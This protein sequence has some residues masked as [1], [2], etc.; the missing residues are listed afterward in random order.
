MAIAATDTATFTVEPLQPFG[1]R[2]SGLDLARLDDAEA[3]AAIKA[4]WAEHLV[5]VFP[6]QHFS[7][8]EQIAF[9]RNFGT[10]AIHGDTDKLSSRRPEILRVTNVG[11]DGEI[12]DSENEVARYFRTLTGF[13]HTDG[14]YK[15]IPSIGSLLHG[16]AVPPEGGETWFCNMFMAYDALSDD[17]KARIEGR[18]MVHYQTFSHRLCPGLTPYTA[19]QEAAQPPVTHPLVRTHANGRKSLYI[20]GTNCYYAGG[21]PLEEGKALHAELMDHGTRDD[22]VY[23]HKWT[24]GD[25][26]MWDNRPTMHRATAYDTARYRRNMQRTEIMGVE[27]V[28]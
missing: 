15:A 28:R 27:P 3:I 1:V 5:L 14:S 6:E 17:L 18:H 13:W 10:L 9:S 25:L 12:L 2:I 23:K 4:L 16:L 21:L 22:F 20:S 8:D 26:V 11:E 24:A 19:E 7:E